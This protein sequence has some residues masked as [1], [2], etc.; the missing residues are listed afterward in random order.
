MVSAAKAYQSNL[1][2]AKT[3]A[4]QDPKVVANI[5]KAWVGGTNE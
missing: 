2:A 1:D 5:I 3:L 4:R